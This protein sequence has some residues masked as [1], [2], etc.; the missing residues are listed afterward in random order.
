MDLWFKKTKQTHPCIFAEV[1]SEARQRCCEILEA[2]LTL[3]SVQVSRSAELQE[4]KMR[5]RCERTKS[6]RE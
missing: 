5:L 2:A 4:K 6:S 3:E 1:D